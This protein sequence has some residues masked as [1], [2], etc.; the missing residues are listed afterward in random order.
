MT[1]EELMVKA[2]GTAIRKELEK[3]KLHLL[4]ALDKIAEYKYYNPS[5]LLK[6]IEDTNFEG[7]TYERF[8][9]IVSM[10]FSKEVFP[11]APISILQQ[12]YEFIMKGIGMKK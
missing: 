7:S 11:H 6:G 9:V 12:S 3:N 2:D 8:W 1:Y 5:V 4:F 10:E